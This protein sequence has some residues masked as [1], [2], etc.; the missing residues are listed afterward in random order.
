[1]A[2]CLDNCGSVHGSC[3]QSLAV[4]ECAAPW[5]NLGDFVPK[6]WLT[7]DVHFEV[8]KALWI[9]AAVTY[10]PLVVLLLISLGYVRRGN[11]TRTRGEIFTIVNLTIGEICG[12]VVSILEATAANPGDRSIGVD[13]LTTCFYVVGEVCVTFHAVY[14]PFI[15]SGTSVVPF[16]VKSTPILYRNIRQLALF[17]AFLFVCIILSNLLVIGIVANPAQV[18]TYI[19]ISFSLMFFVTVASGLLTFAATHGL[20]NKIQSIQESVKSLNDSQKEGLKLTKKRA[21]ATRTISLVVLFL[22]SPQFLVFAISPIALFRAGWA[23]TPIRKIINCL[24][25]YRHPYLSL[26]TSRSYHKSEAQEKAA[27]NW[28]HTNSQQGGVELF[29]GLGLLP[30]M[31]KRRD[32]LS[33]V[34]EE[35]TVDILTDGDSARARGMTS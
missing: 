19:H 10:A 6:P 27:S 9:V 14:L 23:W 11:V 7:C 26:S 13:L 29:I 8:S 28:D 32:L 5:V 1:M 21:K 24:F 30:Y 16:A 20:L 3:N 15:Q 17:Y 18:G 22:H 31:S 4:C 12:L 2:V 25:D 35:R 33:R 34:E